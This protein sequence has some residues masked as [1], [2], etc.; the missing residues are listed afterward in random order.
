[1]VRRDK[2]DAE[3]GGR[4][5]IENHVTYRQAQMLK[6]LGFDWHVSEYYTLDKNNNPV[7]CREPVVGGGADNYNQY[8]GDTSAPTLSIAQ[9]WVRDI[10][11][12]HICI[13]VEYGEMWF[14]VLMFISED[15][16]KEDGCGYDSYEAALSAGIDKILEKK[17]KK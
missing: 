3:G 11:G 14:Y 15:A 10:L 6:R 9:K 8:T 16:E 13:D 2:G 4:M 12:W 17:C 5:N 1:M 7:L